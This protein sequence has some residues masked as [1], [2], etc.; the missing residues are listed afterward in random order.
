MLSK[1]VNSVLMTWCAFETVWQLPCEVLSGLKAKNPQWTRHGTLR[2]MAENRFL[3]RCKSV[4]SVRRHVEQRFQ[5]CFDDMW[6]LWDPLIASLWG[7]ECIDCKTS[8]R[9]HQDTLWQMAENRFLL[10]FNR[11]YLCDPKSVYHIWVL[12]CV[13]QEL[14]EALKALVA[15]AP[16]FLTKIKRCENRFLLRCKSVVLVWRHV[17]QRLPLCFDAMGHLWDRLIASLWGIECIEYKKFPVEAPR[18]T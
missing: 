14:K 4:L 16:N 13:L 9:T 6:H 3:L 1:G 11:V 17:E 12:G 18:H 15:V 2:Q 10:M 7:I 8:R 5:L